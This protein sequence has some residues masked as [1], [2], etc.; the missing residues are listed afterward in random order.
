M[1][2]K[3]KSCKKA[4][5]KLILKN[6]TKSQQVFFSCHA[7]FLHF[8]ADLLVNFLTLV[9]YSL[10]VSSYTLKALEA[11]FTKTFFV[12]ISWTTYSLFMQC[13][14]IQN[15]NTAKLLK[16]ND[17]TKRNRQPGYTLLP[18][19]FFHNICICLLE[20]KIQSSESKLKNTFSYIHVLW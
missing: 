3:K 4:S 16:T 7:D 2:E 5:F 11:K 14:Y 8:T 12:Y 19:I 17:V 13:K 6:G 1:V 9:Q 18:N 15:L 20:K 10:F